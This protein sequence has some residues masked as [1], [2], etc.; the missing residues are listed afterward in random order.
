MNEAQTSRFKPLYL[1]LALIILGFAFWFRYSLAF[2]GVERPGHDERLY[3]GFI[4]Q[5]RSGSSYPEF[6]RAYLEFEESIPEKRVSPLR[7]SYLLSAWFLSTF[8]SDTSFELLRDVSFLASMATLVISGLFA[9]RIGGDRAG[10]VILALMSCAPLQIFN[11]HRALLDGFFS[12]LTLLTLWSLWEC[13]ENPASRVLRWLHAFSWIPLVMA[14]ETSF[15]VMTATILILIFVRD[16]NGQRAG[17]ALWLSSILGAA[18]GFLGLTMLCGGPGP[19]KEL[20]DIALHKQLSDYTIFHAD[21]PWY[22]YLLAIVTLS[23]VIS[24]FAFASMVG[25]GLGDRA[26]R[27][28]LLSI[29]GMLAPLATLPY[30]IVP[31][32][33]ATCD[34]SLRWLCYMQLLWICREWKPVRQ[35]FFLAITVLG[36]C[37]LEV[38]Q[39]HL[40]FH[41]YHIYEPTCDILF[42]VL[43]LVKWTK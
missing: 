15:F 2:A 29:F 23:P 42:Q 20:L 41:V 1:A 3:S 24:I 7:A 38:K 11:A 28:S 32:L 27:F 8:R 39:C 26:G 19:M 5:L 22:G 35:N 33:L 25:P 31:R 18:A 14:K 21:G 13:L 43:K 12:L 6:V 37:I 30:Q 16:K 40:L 10:L 9:R 17:I 34:F 4:D 36:I